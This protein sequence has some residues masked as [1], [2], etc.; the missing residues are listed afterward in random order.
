MIGVD[1]SMDIDNIKNMKKGWF[2]GNFI[3]TMFQTEQFEVAI[4]YYNAGDHEESHY[5]EIATEF[6]AIAKGQAKMQDRILDEGDIVK[7][8]PGESTD[9]SALT[10]VIT[11]VVKIPC[12]KND[13]FFD[14]EGLQC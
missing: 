5:H 2:I 7:I 10:E 8:S 9:F 14:K 4:K 12:V 6:T 11:F 1:D 3:P 13:K